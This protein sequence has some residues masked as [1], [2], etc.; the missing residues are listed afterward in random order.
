MSSTS[1]RYLAMLRMV[2]RY[3]GSIT[4]RE[5]SERLS[6]QGFS[7]TM[8][9]IQRDLEKLSASFPLVV[10]E[11][12]RPFRWSF[13]RDA[14][15]DSIPALDLPTALT[16]E[17]ARAYLTPLLPARTVSH[18]EPHFRQAHRALAGAENPLSHWPERVRVIHRGLPV[19]RPEVDADVLEAVTEGLLRGHCC[20]LTY[21]ARNWRQPEAIVVHPLGLVFRD[22]NI[23]LIATIE[24][25]EGVRQLVLH[26]ASSGRLLEAPV[27]VPA[28]FDLDEYIRG[29]AM[30]LLQSDL[31]V[32]LHLRCDRPVLNHLLEAPLGPDQ[33]TLALDES[34]FEISVTL[35]DTQ[36]LRWWLVAQA[37]HCDILGPQWLRQE[38]VA[39]LRRGLERQQQSH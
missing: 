7:V 20:R 4:T 9:S 37:E 14:S 13:E 22:P 16:L 10:D 3:P 6:R 39:A 15:M 33:Q 21:Q 29:G 30:G 38:T 26:R 11:S 1:V 28:G 5:L 24:G 32:H 18:L 12:C 8:R 35:A 17:L 19:V 34:S 36:D 25:R 31:P 23:Y 2:P 27:Q